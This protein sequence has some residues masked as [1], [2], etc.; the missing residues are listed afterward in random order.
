MHRTLARANPAP[1]QFSLG[2]SPPKPLRRSTS[3]CRPSTSAR[4]DALE[5]GTDGRRW[6]AQGQARRDDPFRRRQAGKTR[7]IYFVADRPE[8][9]R[10]Y[11]KLRCARSLPSVGFL[12]AIIV[13]GL[14][15]AAVWGT[16]VG[17]VLISA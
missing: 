9:R 11:P 4:W 13:I 5:A 8:F 15:S 10:R 16:I 14:G 1:R 6:Q 3:L 17:A 12:A 2:R 7:Q